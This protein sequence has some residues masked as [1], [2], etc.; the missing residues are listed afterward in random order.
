MRTWLSATEGGEYAAGWR[1]RL[2]GRIAAR[3]PVTCSQP[4]DDPHSRERLVVRVHNLDAE[5]FDAA[6]RDHAKPEACFGGH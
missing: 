3:L 2:N 4:R 1:R 5:Y 6:E